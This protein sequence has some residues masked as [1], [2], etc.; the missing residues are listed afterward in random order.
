MHS[1]GHQTTSPRRGR[2]PGPRLQVVI[3]CAEYPPYVQGGLGTYYAALAPK[4]AE[5]ADVTV[6]CLRPSRSVP[7]REIEN[8]VRVERLYCPPVFPL[9]HISFHLRAWIRV[10]RLNADVID[11]VS[12]YGVLNALFDKRPLTTALHTL[13]SDQGGGSF[14]YS[15]IFFKV[16]AMIDSLMVKRSRTVKTTSDFMVQEFKRLWPL[17]SDRVTGIPNGV[18]D[19]WFECRQDKRGAREKLGIPG[20]AHVILTVGRFVPRKG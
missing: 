12:P 1:D 20:N 18:A 19:E 7:A 11:I 4:L 5:I 2:R 14:L 8:G 16:G 15:K 6:V 9:N 17:A 10:R 3:I 13:Y